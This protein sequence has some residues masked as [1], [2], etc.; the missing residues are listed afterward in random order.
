[1]TEETLCS[2]AK[3]AQVG[4]GG[5]E[6][7]ARC[8]FWVGGGGGRGRV[9]IH[10]IQ[11]ESDDWSLATSV[12]GCL[13]E[14]DSSRTAD[15]PRQR[16]QSVHPFFYFFFSK[17]R[18]LQ[19]VET[20]WLTISPLWSGKRL[21]CHCFPFGV[22]FIKRYL[23]RPVCSSLL[24]GHIFYLCVCVCVCMVVCASAPVCLHFRSLVPSILATCCHISNVEVR[25]FLSLSS[26]SDIRQHYGCITINIPWPLGCNL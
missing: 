8:L 4:S 23:L 18:L 5:V 16:N 14:Q 2:A 1:M 10:F 6:L 9:A 12:L 3:R 15:R 25:P 11:A 13:Q 24:Y 19:E 21:L 20:S 26:L 22:N 7:R 17:K